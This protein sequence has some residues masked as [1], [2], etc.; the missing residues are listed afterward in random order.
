[1]SSNLNQTATVPTQE[2]S[3]NAYQRLSRRSRREDF[4]LVNGALGIA[5]E[6]GEVADYIKKIEFHGHVLDK[7]KLKK[8]LGDA[9]WYIATIADL[10]DI[11]LGDVAIENV[12]KLM[13]RYPDGFNE[14]S[15]RSRD[16]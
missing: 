8:E 9:L 6:S 5:G 14:E 7:D 15:S 13:K 10:V 1:M 2:F 4:T 16:T 11:D 3:L 12:A